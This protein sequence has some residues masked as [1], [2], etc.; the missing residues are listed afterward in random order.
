L[1]NGCFKVYGLIKRLHLL[2][3]WFEI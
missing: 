1:H 3:Y 2:Q